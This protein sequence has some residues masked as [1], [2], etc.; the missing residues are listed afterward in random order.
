MNSIQ[1]ESWALRVIDC[2][3]KGQPNEDFLVELKRDW[4]EK[5]KAARR[6]AGHANAARGE[7]ILWLIGV[8]GK[9]G[10]IGVN[11]T[12]I[13]SWYST[14]ESC[15]NELAPRMIPLNIPVDGKTV[16]ALLFE[17][18]HAPFVVKNPVYGSKGAG[19]V[20]L[21]VP[22][23]ENTSVRS[24]RRS[25]LIRLLAPLERLPEIEIIDCDFIATIE[26]TDDRGHYTPDE[27]RLS[28][29]L[30][31]VP[32]NKNRIVIPIHRCKVEFEIIGIPRIKS[33]W[34][35]L[36]PAT[37][38]CGWGDPSISVPLT[39]QSTGHEIIIDAP[40]KLVLKATAERPS[41]PENAKNCDIR[42]FIHLLPT[43]TD[44]PVV[45]TKTLPYPKEQ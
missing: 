33:N 19:A 31:I 29:E 5:E 30:Y 13:A 35:S 7:N 16:V 42:I 21:E 6:I 45:L 32:H 41:L 20:E 14:V 17:T 10:V 11:T 34:L 15:F 44:R 39:I 3:K 2:V 43:G 38:Y 12:D 36:E 27:L 37:N 8:D 25:D 1:I 23:R 4:I 26:K 22:W 28:L 24:A 18:D 40:G 9:Q